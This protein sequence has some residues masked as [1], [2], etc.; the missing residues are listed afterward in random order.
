MNSCI[1]IGRKKYLLTDAQAE[2]IV[3]A[4]RS[5]NSH[6][7][8]EVCLADVPEGQIVK[9]D[10]QEFIVLE[11]AG[12]LTYLIAK[13]LIEETSKFSEKNNNYNYFM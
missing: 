11:H 12:D 8:D 7:P 3:S 10:G 6:S 2:A 1:L 9:I 13:D 4:I 5:A